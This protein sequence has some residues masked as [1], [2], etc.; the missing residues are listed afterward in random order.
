MGERQGKGIEETKTSEDDGGKKARSSRGGTSGEGAATIG[1]E[2]EGPERGER[3]G[4]EG[5]GV[6][7]TVLHFGKLRLLFFGKAK[8]DPGS[9]G[10][11]P[12]PSRT[13]STN[14]NI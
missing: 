4:A 2:G 8:N 10:P 14:T 11:G 1:V 9:E 6:V 3:V 13:S 12:F 7:E 5:A